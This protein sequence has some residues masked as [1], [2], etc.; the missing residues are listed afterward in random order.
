MSHFRTAAAMPSGPPSSFSNFL[1][2]FRE[3]AAG[4]PLRDNSTKC[5]APLRAIQSTKTRPR[6]PRPPVTR[7]VASAEKLTGGVP[8]LPASA[9]SRAVQSTSLG[10]SSCEEEPFWPE[11]RSA[12]SGSR[13]H[14]ARRSICTMPSALPASAASMSRITA[15]GSSGCSLRKALARPQ[16]PAC[17]GRAPGPPRAM[18][19]SVTAWERRVSSQS[20]GPAVPLFFP[21][22]ARACM[23][24]S[25]ASKVSMAAAAWASAPFGADLRPAALTTRTKLDSS[26]AQLGWSSPMSASASEAR[27]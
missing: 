22:W 9:S 1:K 26:P 8:S 3:S 7:Y 18:S 24:R 2:A 27:A 4:C 12:T 23:S 13:P 16:S 20:S 17:S 21:A 19:P 11:E 6:A 5:L 14:S 15:G 10:A 25:V